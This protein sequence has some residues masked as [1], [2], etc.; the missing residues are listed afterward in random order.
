MLGSQGA[1]LLAVMHPLVDALHIP[2]EFL[3]FLLHPLVLVIDG[4]QRRR[5]GIGER[6]NRG[7]W[8]GGEPTTAG[9]GRVVLLLGVSVPLWC[10]I[11]RVCF[12]GVSYFGTAWCLLLTLT[13]IGCISWSE[14]VS[15][16]ART[17]LELL[18]A[19]HL[20]GLFL[21]SGVLLLGKLRSWWNK[22]SR[23]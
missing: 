3:V 16:G 5:V 1:A 19:L 15:A 18:G 21:A 7:I 13:M 8:T 14:S 9:D 23:R 22:A 17:A 12:F 10:R 6:L 11:K 20:A 4:R 2:L